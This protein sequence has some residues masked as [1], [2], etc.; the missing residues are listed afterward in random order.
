VTARATLSNYRWYVLVILT[1]AQ[2]CHGIDRA[3]IGLVLKPLGQ[4]F[5][6]TGSELGLLAGIAYGV[7]LR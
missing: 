3:I 6:L 7:H 4:E 5:H 2:T 1:I